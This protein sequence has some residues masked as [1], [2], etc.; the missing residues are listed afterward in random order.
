[1]WLSPPITQCVETHSFEEC[2]GILL[3]KICERNYNYEFYINMS[4]CVQTNVSE[5]AH[6]VIIYKPLDIN[7]SAVLLRQ[8]AQ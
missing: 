4:V 7:Y 1:M 6:S 3:Q 2:R 5:L 8:T